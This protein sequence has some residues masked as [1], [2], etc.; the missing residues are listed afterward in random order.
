[1]AYFIKLTSFQSSESVVVNVELVT[2]FKKHGD[3]TI[4]YFGP[5][6]YVSVSETPEQVHG[7][8][9]GEQSSF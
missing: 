1:M 8:L 5:D 7:E 2:H 6:K 3:A 9:K 4:L